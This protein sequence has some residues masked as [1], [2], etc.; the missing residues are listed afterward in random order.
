MKISKFISTAVCGLAV[1]LMVVG[2]VNGQPPRGGFGAFG[3]GGGFER[4]QLAT[5]AEVATELKLTD[6]Q[7]KAAADATA[8]VQEEQTAAFQEAQNGGGD[9]AAVQTKM[10]K[11][12]TEQN[13]KFLATLN[14][15]Q[16]TRLT[17][18]YIQ[19]VNANALQD[20]EVQKQLK[21]TEDQ[22]KKLGEVVQQ[23]VE[24]G[25]GALQGG[26]DPD[27]FQK[28]QDDN[29]KALLAV[30]NDDQKKQWDAL[31]GKELTMDLTQLRRGGFN[32]GG[33]RGGN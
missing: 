29:N 31:K 18:L 12:R 26:F 4:Y 27:A 22:V 11:V 25:R 28:L 17:G 13:E 8:K 15:D 10:A 23:N 7:K 1:G 9:F 6:E 21:L 32:R 16:K 2:F 33:R 5:L 14:A 24:R 20:P 3:R 19:A 30:L